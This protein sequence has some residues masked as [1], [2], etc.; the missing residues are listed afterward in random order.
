M[1]KTCVIEGCEKVARSRHGFC[2][3]HYERWRVHGDPNITLRPQRG[4]PPEEQY[5]R[6]VDRTSTPDG[7]HLWTGPLF[8]N[9]YGRVKY[10]GVEQL[11]HRWGYQHYVGPIPEGLVVRHTC[12]V[13]PCQN[14]AHWLTGTLADN[15]RDRDERGRTRMGELHSNARLSSVQVDEIRRRYAAGGVTQAAL[16]AEF[17]VSQVNISHIIRRKLWKQVS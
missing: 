9:G 13:R 8:Q 10:D 14:P 15:N 3:M 6:Y 5:E 16:G 2:G 1:K 17:G 12:D 11:A 7:C 4:L